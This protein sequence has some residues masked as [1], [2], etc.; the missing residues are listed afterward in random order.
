LPTPRRLA[1]LAI[2]DPNGAPIWPAFATLA[3]LA[4]NQVL[5]AGA[6]SSAAIAHGFATPGSCVFLISTQGPLSII[7]G[8]AGVGAA[9]VDATSI[10][11]PAAGV[12]LVD[13]GPNPLFTHFRHIRAGAADAIFQISA[14]AT[15]Q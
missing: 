9:A 14:V 10:M 5:T 3:L 4:G 15:Q 13:P 7:F 6:A 8:A 11:L 1:A 2:G 12:Y